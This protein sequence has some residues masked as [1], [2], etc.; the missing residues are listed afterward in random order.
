MDRSGFRRWR[1]VRPRELQLARRLEKQLRAFDRRRHPLL[2][3]RTSERRDAFVEQLVESMRR[4][5]YVSVISTRAV[6]ALRADPSSPLFDPVKAAILYQRAGNIEEAF[7]MVFLFVHFGKHPHTGW[8]LARD[9]YGRL[10][11]GGP[12][13]W[14]RMHSHPGRLRGWLASHE[15]ILRGGDGIPRHFG[16]HRKH[17]TLSDSSL[18]GTGRVIESYVNWVSASGSHARLV[19]DVQQ[20]TNHEPRRTFDLLYRSM[21]NVVSFGRLARFDYLTMVGKLGLADIEPGSVYLQNATGPLRGARLLF[22]GNREA[23]LITSVLDEWLVELEAALSLGMQGM[24]ALEDALCNWQK[25]PDHFRSF[26]A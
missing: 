25:S 11:R 15:T 3:L 5:R 8:R 16:N 18:R 20:Q 24:Q 19:R 17:E 1:I 4:I 7:W 21:A 23:G 9:I 12:W 26:R 2:G 22:G 10:G 6:S 13:T 14:T